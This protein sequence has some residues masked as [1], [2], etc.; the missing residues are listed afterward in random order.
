[1]I[2]DLEDDFNLYCL[3]H[4]DLSLKRNAYNF[5][6]SQTCIRT[7]RNP[8]IKAYEIA[9]SIDTSD[10]GDVV[11]GEPRFFSDVGVNIPGVKL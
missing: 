4:K 7:G 9:K 2:N 3:R 1:M 8:L 10:I 5:V 11:Y 6:R